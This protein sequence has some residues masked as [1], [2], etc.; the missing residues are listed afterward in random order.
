MSTTRHITLTE[1]PNGRWTAYDTASQTVTEG[2][3][4]TEALDNLDEAIGAVDD[5]GER[6]TAAADESAFARRL[7]RK[8]I[9]NNY[10]DDYFGT[11]PD[12]ADDL[13][14]LGENA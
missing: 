3:T 6:D 7:S 11:H 12:W 9:A 5:Q 1:N 14:D 8:S 2:A 10:G 13:P 4:R